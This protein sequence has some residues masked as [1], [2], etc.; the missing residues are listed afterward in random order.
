MIL[1]QPFHFIAQGVILKYLLCICV[2]MFSAQFASADTY[3]CAKMIFKDG[4]LRNYEYLGNT[5]GANT[6]KSGLVSS[7]IGSSIEKTT[8]SVDPGVTTGDS[9]STTQYT[10]S[11]GECS[12]LE[13]NITWQMRDQYIEQN[14][15]GIKKEIAIGEGQHVDSLAFLSGCKGID[16]EVWTRSLQ[17][18]TAGFYDSTSSK[19]FSEKLGTV[20]KGNQQLQSNCTII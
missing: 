11:W 7:S 6:K 14:M 16:H 20:I 15:D 13:Y 1:K 4:W 3:S 10:S 9:V 18:N 19:D 5:W 17:K 8:S 2:L 12:M